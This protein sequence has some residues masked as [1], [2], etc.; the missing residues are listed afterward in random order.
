MSPTGQGWH[1]NREVCQPFVQTSAPEEFPFL[2]PKT[3]VSKEAK[4]CFPHPS[5]FKRAQ[6]RQGVRKSP[7]QSA[8]EPVLSWVP[9]CTAA[10][11]ILQQSW[12]YQ[13]STSMGVCQTPCFETKQDL[14][15]QSS[16]GPRGIPWYQQ[17]KCPH[18]MSSSVIGL[19]LWLLL[20][21]CT[22]KCLCC[23]GIPVVQNGKLLR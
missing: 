19:V 7:I 21:T 15:V 2:V 12:S 4:C 6:V 5:T 16:T 9:A 17:T 18:I 14:S 3:H 8:T 1:T 10:A 20:W 23:A 22:T 13:H 11:D